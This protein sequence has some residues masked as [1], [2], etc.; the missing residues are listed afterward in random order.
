MSVFPK[1]PQEFRKIR[2]L[3]LFRKNMGKITVNSGVFIYN[4]NFGLNI[5]DEGGFLNARG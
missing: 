2:N 1:I 3:K 4:P 5:R